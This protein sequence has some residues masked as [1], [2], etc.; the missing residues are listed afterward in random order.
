MF[1]NRNQLK[2]KTTQKKKAVMSARPMCM[3]SSRTLQQ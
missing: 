2:K 1:I 3:R